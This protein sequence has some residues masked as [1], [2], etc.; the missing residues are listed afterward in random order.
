MA[1]ENSETKERMRAPQVEF[2]PVRKPIQATTRPSTPV[3]TSSSS[4][5]K[6]GTQTPDEPELVTDTVYEFGDQ[7]GEE[8]EV[9]ETVDLQ[10]VDIPEEL[11]VELTTGKVDPTKFPGIPE[12]QLQMFQRFLM[13]N[14]AALTLG[15]DPLTDEDKRV[16]PTRTA[17]P[18]KLLAMYERGS[19]AADRKT[20][21]EGMILTCIG[22]GFDCHEEV[23]VPATAVSNKVQVERFICPLCAELCAKHT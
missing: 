23:F 4:S 18:M 22:V 10:E 15:S 6:K 20:K 16:L 21:E 7:D 17:D 1:S 5:R 9:K 12:E 14:L 3:P 11:W 19:P 13:E 2:D 8:V